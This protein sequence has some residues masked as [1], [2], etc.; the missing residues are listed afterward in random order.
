MSALR[1]SVDDYLQVRRALG[2]KLTIHG[3][4][5]PQFPRFIEQQDSTVITTSLALESRPSRR[6]PASCGGI[7]VWREGVSSSV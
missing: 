5:L 1:Q 6:T 7:S 3:R 4:V 2:Y